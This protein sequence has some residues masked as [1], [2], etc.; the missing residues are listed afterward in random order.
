[1]FG[2]SEVH[3]FRAEM[4]RRSALEKG[5][6]NYLE[7]CWQASSTSRTCMAEEVQT[8]EGLC[9]SNVGTCKMVAGVRSLNCVGPE[10]A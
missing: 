2:G 10:A 8:S 6:L 5:M 9:S 3:R 4:P 7:C 1:M